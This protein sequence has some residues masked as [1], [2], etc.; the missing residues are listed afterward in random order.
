MNIFWKQFRPYDFI[1]VLS[2]VLFSFVPVAVFSVTN[3]YV[4][5]DRVYAV[6][7]IDGDE[8]DR[9]PL[10]GNT[11]HELI[12]YYPSPGKYNIIE[13][14]GERIRNKEDNSPE[15]V[16]VKT[17]WIDTP[18]EISINIPHR[19]MIEIKSENVTETEF[20]VLSK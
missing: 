12:T 16:S 20:D 15:Q 19:L 7:S 1:I 6:I 11:E 14:E 17:G 18:G 2:L 5:G 10:T 13:I 3:P 4:E 8:V 9:F